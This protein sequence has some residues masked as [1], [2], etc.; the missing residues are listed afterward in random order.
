VADLLDLPIE[1]YPHDILVPRI[2][3]LRDNM[4]AYDAA[5]VALA[6]AMTDDGAELVTADARLARAARAACSRR[7]YQSG[8]MGTWR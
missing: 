1:R 7:R 6:E 5:S 2:W 3:E 8:T 4:S